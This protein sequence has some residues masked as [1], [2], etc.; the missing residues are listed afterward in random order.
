MAQVALR[1]GPA[2]LME[3][4]NLAAYKFVDLPAPALPS[5]QDSLRERCGAAEFRGTI[6]LSTEGIN[7]MLAG[8]RDRLDAFAANL[9]LDPRIGSLPW[10]R[11]FS[12]HLPFNRM[13]VKIK[14]EIIACGDPSIRPADEP[15]EYMPPRELKQRLD[16]GDDVVLLDTRN[17]YETALGTFSHARTIPMATFRSFSDHVDALEDLDPERPIVTFCTGGIR[18]EKAAIALRRRGFRNVYQLE[19]GILRYFEDC[20][21]EH[22]DGECF[23]YDRRVALDSRLRETETAQCFNCLHPVSPA[24]QQ[25]AAYVHGV[26]CPRCASDSADS[27]ES[28]AEQDSPQRK[29]SPERLG[30][31]TTTAGTKE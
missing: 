19:G 24:E 12:D 25:S 11:S 13:L 6:L 5:L 16:A 17:D 2:L 31:R 20:G 8:V 14:R 18:C 29:L 3:Y 21:G 28:T 23:V 1:E 9:E 26:S 7:L 4:L 10:K 22:F 27:S 15:A 30:A